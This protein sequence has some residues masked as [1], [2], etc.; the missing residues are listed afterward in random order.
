M[1]I[2]GNMGQIKRK[3]S[4]TKTYINK[5]LENTSMSI[6]PRFFFCK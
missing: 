2:L 6:C 3:H 1:D 5:N 4:L